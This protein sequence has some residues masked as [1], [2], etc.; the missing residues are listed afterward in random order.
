MVASMAVSRQMLHSKVPSW[1]LLSPAPLLLPLGPQH[2]SS[3]G[4]HRPRTPCSTSSAVS[5]LGVEFLPREIL[6]QS[7]WPNLGSQPTQ[8]LVN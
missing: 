7:V 4:T 1:P 3:Q 6:D 2:S 5:K 8:T